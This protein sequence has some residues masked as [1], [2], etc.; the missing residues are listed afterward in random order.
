MALLMKENLEFQELLVD[1]GPFRQ[2][3]MR[4]VLLKK[5][6]TVLILYYLPKK[7]LNQDKYLIKIKAELRWYRKK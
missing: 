2:Y 4:K 3:I 6:I 5:C 1:D 7:I